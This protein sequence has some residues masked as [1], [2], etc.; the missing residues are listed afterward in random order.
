MS[1]KVMKLINPYTGEMQCSVCG[2]QH[3]ANIKSQS[4]GRFYRGSWHC[5][6]ERCPSNQKIWDDVKKRFVKAPL[7]TL[8]TA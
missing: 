8:T 4:G 2:S 1:H 7:D 3:F 6:N 5:S